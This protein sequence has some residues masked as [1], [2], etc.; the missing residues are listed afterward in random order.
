MTEWLITL[1]P[2]FLCVPQHANA[3][4][5]FNVVNA[6][7]NQIGKINDFV[8]KNIIIEQYW[9]HVSQRPGRNGSNKLAPFK[10]KH[11]SKLKASFNNK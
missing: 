4:S 9:G 6:E 5:R 2:H 11:F 1:N 7:H 3:N 8:D 10:E